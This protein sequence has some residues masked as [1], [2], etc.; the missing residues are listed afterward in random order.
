MLRFGTD[1]V[2]GRVGVDLDESHIARLGAAVAQVW[3][4]QAMV[5]GNDGRESGAGWTLA[6]AGGAQSQGASVTSA[7]VVPTPAIARIAAE[8]G[9]V[10]VA[11]TASHNSWH[12]NGVKVFAPGGHKLTDAEQQRIEALWQE[13]SEATGGTS[14]MSDGASVVNDDRC[15]PQYV[16]AMTRVF[17]DTADAGALSGTAVQIDAANGAT[18]QV[19]API[20]TALGL[21]ATIHHAA[22]NGRNIND[23]CG[24]VHPESLA[25]AS[26]RHGEIGLAFDGDGDRVIAVDE[27]GN[28][29]DGDRLIALMALDLRARRQLQH[30]TVVV[31]SMTNLGFHRAMQQ[32]GVSVVT[33]D[34]GD[35]AVLAAMDEGGFVLGGEQS[36]HIIHS[37]DATT[38]DGILAALQLLRI[39][40]ESGNTLTELAANVMQRMP[41]L[42]RNVRVTT[43]PADVELLLGDDLARE[44]AALGDDGRI[45]VR[46]S[47]TEP[48]VRIMVE[49]PTL[50]VAE[51]VADRLA[52][53][54][55]TRA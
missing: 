26:A 11:I 45:V 39:V 42:L 43:K 22:P 2:R 25:A 9:C 51:A 15:A 6:F 14:V 23:G 13:S 33:T 37:S 29:V 38:G 35:R 36:G 28:V 20:M 41:Q 8:R 54:V 40:R 3:P 18:S 16:A 31:T 19:V 53:L 55:T 1:G 10:G 24:A 32:H 17:T 30:D 46:A 4:R 7:G 49:A 5:I 50:E 34:V 21:R 52:Q 44:R 12:D 27:R 47:G 48:L